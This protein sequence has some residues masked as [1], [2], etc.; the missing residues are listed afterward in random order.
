[1]SKWYEFLKNIFI[2]NNTNNDSSN[3]NNS[4]NRNKA[5]STEDIEIPN[6]VVENPMDQTRQNTV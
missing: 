4:G 6:V 5:R 1:M 3:G 2:A